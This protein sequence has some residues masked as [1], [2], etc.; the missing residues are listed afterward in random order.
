MKYTGGCHCKNVRFEVQT[1]EPIKDVISCNCSMCSKRGSLLKFVPATQ[2]T[3]LSGADALTDYQFNRHIIHHTFCN[4][5]GI[6][7]FAS[8][9]G[10]DGVETRAINVRCL[11]DIDL[12]ALHV[13]E[14][15]GKS[16]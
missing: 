12:D 4:T 5:C 13:V 6:L 2:F 16:V 15:D 1:D 11:D 14:Y 7:P 9:V 3:L 8:G 10:P